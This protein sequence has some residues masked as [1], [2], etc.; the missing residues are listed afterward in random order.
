MLD[1]LKR[2][3]PKHKVKTVNNS[4]VNNDNLTPSS[5]AAPTIELHNTV[6]PTGRE[7]VTISDDDQM[8]LGEQIRTFVIT[9]PEEDE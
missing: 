2:K 8:P 5:S 3:N 7:E 4:V 1:D 9:P 6:R